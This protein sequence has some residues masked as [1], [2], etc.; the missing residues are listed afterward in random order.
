MQTR[1]GSRVTRS[2]IAALAHFIHVCLAVR[3]EEVPSG[4]HPYEIR[5]YS[6][7]RLV[8]EAR[9]I[10]ERILDA[11]NGRVN[12]LFFFFFFG[13]SYASSLPLLLAVLRTGVISAAHFRTGYP[14]AHLGT[15]LVF[16]VII[17]VVIHE[18]I[19][20]NAPMNMAAGRKLRQKKDR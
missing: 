16:K 15:C 9:V 8:V 7:P 18:A 6:R 5:S 11:A 12:S 10:R 14:R 17:A 4:G 20:K 3:P 13:I 1:N 2:A 19:K